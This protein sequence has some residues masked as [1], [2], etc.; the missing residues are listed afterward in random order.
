M[1]GGK[2]R[3]VSLVSAALLLISTFGASGVAATTIDF[4]LQPTSTVASFSSSGVIITGS[5]NLDFLAGK[6]LGVEGGFDHPSLGPVVDQGESL[7][8]DFDAGSAANGVQ[9][10]VSLLY[11]PNGT[12]GSG[13]NITG[14]D[15]NGDAISTA[16]QSVGGSG[17]ISISD[18]FGADLTGFDVVAPTDGTQFSQLEYDLVPVPAPS[19]IWLVGSG[20]LGLACIAKRRNAA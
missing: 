20:L 8:F 6:G 7:F 14:Y 18:L 11:N 2:R 15:V 1:L 4:S 10:R 19:A 3:S 12:V 9:I 17:W 13:L 16:N 5:A